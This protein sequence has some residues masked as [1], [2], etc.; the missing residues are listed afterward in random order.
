LREIFFTVQIFSLLHSQ[1]FIKSQTINGLLRIIENDENKSVRIFCNANATA[2]QATQNHANNGVKSIQRFISNINIQ[3]HHTNTLMI[4]DNVFLAV[5]SLRSILSN[6]IFIHFITIFIKNIVM[7][8]KK[9][10]FNTNLTGSE[11]VKI[12]IEIYISI[13]IINHFGILYNT[14]LI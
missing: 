9:I 13:E 3:N 11:N 2:I 1:I 10:D 6:D 12:L 8:N 4:V 14:E 7:M 5:L